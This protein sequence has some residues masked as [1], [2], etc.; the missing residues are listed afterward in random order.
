MSTSEYAPVTQYRDD[1]SQSYRD[2]PA[3][4]ASNDEENIPSIFDWGDSR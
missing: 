1:P 4:T 2:N 3:A